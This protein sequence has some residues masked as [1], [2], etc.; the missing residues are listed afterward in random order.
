M[1]E[2]K[3]TKME[4]MVELLSKTY[5]FNVEEALKLC[6]GNKKD[7][8]EKK[9]KKV[10]VSDIFVELSNVELSN[11]VERDV[12]V[13]EK[14][15]RTEKQQAAF[16]K[17]K[18]AREEKLKNKEVKVKEVKEKK[19]RT[20]KQQAAFE[21]MKIAR[22]EKLKEKK[23]AAASGG[24]S[25]GVVTEVEEITVKKMVYEGKEYLLSKDNT[26]YDEDTEEVVGKWDDK[27]NKI[28]VAEEL[29]EE[30]IDE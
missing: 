12:E 19:P 11:N 18:A 28:V 4:K 25:S 30:Q 14:K 26:V 23:A 2:V 15:A 22:Q 16:E 21:K 6:K 27:E 1:S 5:N 17:M 3:M 20:E 13:K 24:S 29:E 7:K 8:K 10:E 9:N